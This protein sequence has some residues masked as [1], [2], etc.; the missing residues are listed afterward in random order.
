MTYEATGPHPS[1]SLAIDMIIITCLVSDEMDHL[2]PIRFD[3]S[4]LFLKQYE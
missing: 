1:A 4:A 3:L 2:I